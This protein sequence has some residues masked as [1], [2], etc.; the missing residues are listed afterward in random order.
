MI[1][2]L[3]KPTDLYLGTNSSPPP[4]PLYLRLVRGGIIICL[5]RT[6]AGLEDY[7]ELAMGTNKPPQHDH[8][9][10]HNKAVFDGAK[11]ALSHLLP[12]YGSTL[13]DAQRR[14][15]REA[16]GG[17]RWQAALLEEVVKKVVMWASPKEED[18]LDALLLEDIEMV[19][20]SQ[21]LMVPHQYS[22]PSHGIRW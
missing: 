6:L 5:R 22:I 4:L 13:S 1:S 18:D 3:V 21:L 15:R 17:Q 8:Q 19:R 16:V 11:E 14:V 9:H 10:I 12:P 20:F 2:V 7:L